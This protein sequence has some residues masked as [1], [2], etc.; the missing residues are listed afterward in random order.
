MDLN[1]TSLL[2]SSGLL[3]ALGFRHGL[4]PDHIAV[5]D[6]M[7]RLR[8]N[9]SACWKARLTGFQFAA[10][11]SLT[12][13]LAT[14]VF[15][16][17]GVQLPE[18]L[19]AVGL[20]IST[21]FL[22]WLAYRNFK[23][24]FSGRDEHHHAGGPVQRKIL[25]AMG[26]LAHPMGVGFGFAISFDSLAQ[27][28][29]MAAKGHELGGF[30]AIVALALS[31][32]AGMVM[33]DASNGLLMHWLINRSHQLAHQAGRIMSGVVATLS[34]TVVAVGHSSQQF[35][36]L[37]EI[38]DAWGGYIGIGV[39]GIALLVYIT[40]ARFYKSKNLNWQDVNAHGE[41]HRR[42]RAPSLLFPK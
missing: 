15:Y 5:V 19:D 40:S 8:H 42:G 41:H 21:F 33:A 1:T 28:G 11:H 18:W 25:Q 6:G 34:L 27:A 7:T 29:L 3:L 24:C 23:F 35:T 32:G 26:P 17:Y 2:A 39:T 13:L 36:Q 14:F 30:F 16:L 37:E 9:G 22:L 4:D 31:F 20:W 12:I 38:W 10:G